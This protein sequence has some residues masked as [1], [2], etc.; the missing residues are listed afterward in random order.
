[1]GDPRRLKKKFKRPN[2]PFEKE[3]IETEL[4]Y[5]GNY[6]LRNKREFWKHKYQLSR[7]RKIARDVK[8][9]PE[10]LKKIQLEELLG[11]ANRLGLVSSGAT[12]DDVLSLTIEDLLNRRLQS[13]VYKKGIARTIYQ[14]RQLVTHKHI[15]IKGKIISSPS[16]LVRKDEEDGIGFN[17]FSP[18]KGNPEK[19][20]PPKKNSSEKPEKSEKS[21]RRGRPDN[22]RRG[23]KSTR[24]RSGSGRKP[25]ASEKSEK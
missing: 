14:A 22:G 17:E 5:L 24:K 16:Y 7:L 15:S 25:K 23:K 8:A 11:R 1:M 21:E 20:I 13:I 3:R 6:G 19:L 9:M 12:S 18:L 10:E 2:S 4:K